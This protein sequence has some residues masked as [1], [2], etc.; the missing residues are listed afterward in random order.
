MADLTTLLTT[1]REFAGD[2]SS[3]QFTDA[4][5]TRY[6]NFAL[7][8]IA[9]Q[10]NFVKATTTFAALDGNTIDGVGGVAVPADFL[11]EIEVRWNGIRLNRLR[12]DE[13][14]LR[15]EAV[16]LTTD[17]PQYYTITPMN[18]AA[19]GR[20]IIFYPYQGLTQAAAIFMAYIG[21]PTALV[22]GG[23]VPKL[24]EV[25]HDAV[26]YY[27]TSRV[28]AAEGDIE[29][30]RYFKSEYAQIISEWSSQ[31]YEAGYNENPQVRED[32]YSLQYIYDPSA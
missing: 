9:R 3:A 14:F 32:G 16:V 2:L 31:V 8:E 27:A 21:K 15:D 25:L 13:F 5:I 24:P 7:G 12:Y 30:A 20:R 6:I 19:S 17:P 11:Q 4:Q 22:A 23:D 18:L 29:G 10:T 26:A 28:K 1:V